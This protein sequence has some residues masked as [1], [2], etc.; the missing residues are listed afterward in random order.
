MGLALAGTLLCCT[1]SQKIPGNETLG[2]FVFDA[3]L[4]AGDFVDLPDGGFGFSAVISR[5]KPDAGSLVSQAF[6]V[7]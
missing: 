7:F 1:S 4:L 2:T 5:F 3:G 6:V